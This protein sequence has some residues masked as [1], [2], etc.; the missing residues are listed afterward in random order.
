[1]DRW[2]Y[3]RLLA[4][5]GGGTLAP[6]NTLVACDVGFR[7]GYRAVEVDAVLCADEVPVLLHDAS[8]ERTTNG[9]GSIDSKTAAEL[10]LLDAGSWFHP[11]FAHARIPTLEQALRHCL[12]RGIWL[13]VEIKPVPGKEVRTGQV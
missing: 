11:D 5:R 4:H 6:E 8:L 10:A 13:N 12:E 7:Y 1:M 2:P 3:P 9:R